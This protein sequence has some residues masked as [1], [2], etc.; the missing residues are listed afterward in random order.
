VI[1]RT[2]EKLLL[3]VTALQCMLHWLSFLQLFRLDEPVCAC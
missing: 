2:V 3:L 1:V